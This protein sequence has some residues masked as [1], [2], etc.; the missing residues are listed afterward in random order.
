M[1]VIGIS[2]GVG[3]GKSSV[4][5]YIEENYDARVVQADEVG[6][7]LMLPGGDCYQ[8]VIELFGEWIVMADG[9]LDRMKIAE[10]VFQ[11]REMLDR[12]DGIIHPAVKEYIKRE[13]ARARK[14]DVP[15]FFIEAALLI[16]EKYDEIYDEL[17]VVYCEPQVR[18]ERLRNDRGYTDQRID[19]IL[20][21]QLS[22]DEYEAAADFVLY[23]SEDVEHT[24]LQIDRR[25]RKYETM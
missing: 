21:N 1:R 25:M 24:H 23:N 6:Y 22:D 3:S 9:T 4:L 20:A 15:Y 8:E 18:R 19:E 5:N 2:G 13:V 12:L 7:L 14:E 17:W 11:K 10:I 16:E